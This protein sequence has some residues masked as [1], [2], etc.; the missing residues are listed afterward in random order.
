MLKDGG[1]YLLAIWDAIERNRLSDVAQQTLIELFPDN[2]PLFIREGPF[3]YA[4]TLAIESDLHDAGFQTVD[5]E[6]MEFGSR[7]PSAHDAA[8]AFCYGTPMSMEIEDREPGSLERAFVAVEEAFRKFE[9]ANGI[10]EPMAA[11]IV[12]A[13]K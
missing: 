9:G 3:G 6:T 11:H 8:M 13:T 2:P 10:D 12:T 5:V 1:H 4:D 7:S